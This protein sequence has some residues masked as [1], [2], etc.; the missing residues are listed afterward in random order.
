MPTLPAQAGQLPLFHV[1]GFTG[2]RQLADPAGTAAAVTAILEELRRESPGE[3]IALSSA[4]AGADLVFV[5]TA[6]DLGL[7][8]EALLPLPLL[9]F[10]R[11]FA[12]EARPEV[13]P[14]PAHAERAAVSPEPPVVR[15]RRGP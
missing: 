11:D 14:L 6:L 15:G 7:G 10:Q 4:A 5:R 2:H 9:D 13:K 12:T 3:W 1:V 8:W